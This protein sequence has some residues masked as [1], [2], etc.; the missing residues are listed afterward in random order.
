[1]TKKAWQL[2]RSVWNA[3][4]KRECLKAEEKINEEIFR[5]SLA[6][7]LNYEALKLRICLL[8][9]EEGE[10][11]YKTQLSK[12]KKAE[13]TLKKA[14]LRWK[15]RREA[16]KAAMK[17]HARLR[18]RCAKSWRGKKKRATKSWNAAV[19]RKAFWRKKTQRRRKYKSVEETLCESSSKAIYIEAWL[20]RRK[21]FGFSENLERES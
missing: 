18:K 15:R 5:R 17:R 2:T 3:I 9:P 1:M 13:A 19:Y 14:A 21:I 20:W 8:R 6:F 16:E 11:Y 12:A 4:V 10:V 7:S